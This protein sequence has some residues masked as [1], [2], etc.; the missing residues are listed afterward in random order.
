MTAIERSEF[1]KQ[2]GA[3]T[4]ILAAGG[5]L[6]LGGCGPG[7]DTASGRSTMGG[8]TSTRIAPDILPSGEPHLPFP[9]DFLWGTATA[10]HQVEG[11]NTNNNWY[12]FEQGPGRIFEGHRSGDGA[13]G[14]RGERRRTSRGWWR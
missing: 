7:D 8:T 9:S 12:A 6:L 13:S 4:G 11:G 14:G 5:P 10:A 3:A 2:I 1:I